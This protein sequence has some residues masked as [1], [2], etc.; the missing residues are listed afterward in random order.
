VI[1]DDPVIAGARGTWRLQ[2]RVGEPLP[3]GSRIRV[4]WR[5]NSDWARPQ[6][7]DPRGPDYAT[8]HGPPGVRL[9]ALHRRHFSR[10]YWDTWDWGVE[11]IVRRGVLRAGDAVELTL[12]DRS[13]GAPGTWAQTFSEERFRWRILV[14]PRGARRFTTLPLAPGLAIRPGPPARLVAFSPAILRPGAPFA[15]LVHAEDYFGNPCRVPLGRL[16]L[17]APEGAPSPREVAVTAVGE[18]ISR[19]TTRAPDAP[20]PLDLRVSAPELNLSCSVENSRISVEDPPVYWGDLHVHTELSDGTGTVAENLVFA[21]DTAALD[22]CVIT[23][24]GFLLE[25]AEWQRI[26]EVTAE[27]SEEGRFI[28]FPGFEFSA[29]T[30]AGGDR[31]VI[32]YQRGPLYRSRKGRARVIPNARALFRALRKENAIIIPH[33][34]GRRA[35]WAMHD[36]RLEPLA[37]ICSVHGWF[38][39]FLEE[40]FARGYRPGIVGSG[41]GHLG[42]P[43]RTFPG[44]TWARKRNGLAAILAP[45][46]ERR[47]IWRALRSRRTYA[48]TGPRI[49]LDLR[50]D[51]SPMGSTLPHRRSITLSGWAQGAVPLAE[52]VLLRDDQPVRR[53][54]LRKRSVRF[55]WREAVP[56][57]GA[58]FRIELRQQDGHRAWSSPIWVDP[59]K[60]PRRRRPGR[61]RRP[62]P[63]AR[64]RAPTP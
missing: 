25:D 16:E 11:I 42:H 27:L 54:E 22:V 29:E 63:P 60:R 4:A 32:Y 10:P 49:L 5:H 46:L 35:N 47:E 31:N 48:T 39:E 15:I 61:S 53:L 21:R 17:A 3:R 57:A 8:V 37:E 24:H 28:A 18:G 1:P 26:Q 9:E 44:L 2:L 13:Q 14:R 38:P 23:D 30:R 64:R 62:R 7:E 12:G 20:G 45:R 36:P 56:P 40:A 52:L 34:G 50:G 58:A 41:D 51:G 55:H 43:G 59:A 33:V 6:F 19:I